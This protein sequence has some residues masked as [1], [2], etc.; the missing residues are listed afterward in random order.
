MTASRPVL[1]KIEQD[2][3]SHWD[4]DPQFPVEDWRREV[5]ED[6]IRLGYL[7]WV[8]HQ[9]EAADDESVSVDP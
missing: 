4:E 9:R 5:A 6:H 3:A 1:P 8:T 2:S 7:E